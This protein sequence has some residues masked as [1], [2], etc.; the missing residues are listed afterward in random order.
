MKQLPVL[1]L[2]LATAA[3][4]QAQEIVKFKDSAKNPPIE[5][6]IVGLTCKTIE[7]VTGGVKQT[8]DAGRVAEI[9][10]SRKSPDY[11]KGEEALGKGEFSPAIER[12]ERVSTDARAPEA[13]RQLASIQTVRCAAANSD[14]AGVVQ[15][16]QVLRARKADSFFVN[17]SFAWEVKSHIALGNGL[18]ATGALRAFAAIAPGNPD[19]EFLEADFAESQNN[20][21]GALATYRKYLRDPLFAVTAAL[22]EM[23]C[24]T[25]QSDWPGLGAVA[26]DHLKS[27]MGK[28]DF[29][30]RILIAAYTAKGDVDLNGGKAKDAL[31]NYLQ[32]A[33][34]L[35][36][37][38][39]PENETALA[40]SA[41]ACAKLFAAEKDPPKKARYRTQAQEMRAELLK[42]YPKTRY[43]VDIDNSVQNL[44]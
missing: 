1:L 33:I 31:M 4:L 8:L 21:K 7:I 15:A 30:Q 37:E 35:N 24:L 3:T 41:L 17:E 18:G 36:K 27:A 2:A 11:L 28:R 20:W 32:G 10:T 39:S 16:A 34:V 26:D 5:G 25:A 19:V 6:E 40:R 43:R 29:S 13:L 42:L 22:G 12:F 9:I 38:T 44:R 14:H 23:R